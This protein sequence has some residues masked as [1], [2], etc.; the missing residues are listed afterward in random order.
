M[1]DLNPIILD[2][3]RRKSWLY[4]DGKGMSRICS[5]VVDYSR[6]AVVFLEE[7]MF[8]RLVT[9]LFYE[10]LAVYQAGLI[11]ARIPLD[12]DWMKA[13]ATDIDLLNDCAR[14]VASLAG[15]GEAAGTAEGVHRRSDRG[16][17][18]ARSVDLGRAG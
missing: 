10:L 11:S 6:D 18:H 5:T 13:L 14:I 15:A 2:M 3:F 7:A 12:K 8:P 16:A 9:M 4:E 1:A 17:V